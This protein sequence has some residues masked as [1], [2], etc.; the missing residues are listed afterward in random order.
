MNYTTW[1]RL[2]L[3]VLFIA[4]HGC[5]PAPESTTEAVPSPEAFLAEVNTQLEVLGKQGGAAGWVRSTYITED[6]G[7][8]AARASEDYLKFHSES[9]ARARVY[10]GQ[11]L[12]ARTR[13][14]LM[15]LKLGTSKPAPNDVTKRKQ[16]AEISVRMPG[17]YGAGKYC[18]DADEC[19]GLD[20]LEPIM[21]ASRDYDEL[22]EAWLGWR[23]ISPPMRDDYQQFVALAKEGARELG[24]SDLGEMW[25]SGYDMS[26]DEFRGEA[27]GLWEQVSPLYEELHCYVRDRLADTYGEDKVSRDGPIPAHLLGN[28]WAQ[29][30]GEIYDLV[31][32]YPGVADL[33]VDSALQE[34][35]YTAE[36]MTRNAESFFTSLGLPPLPDTFWER[37]MLLKPAD[38]EVICHASAWQVLGANDVRIKMCI[39]PIQ[40]H[41]TTIYHELGHIYY[42][43]A[44]HDK[45]ALHRSGAH[46]GFHEAIGDAITLSMTP[47]YL[48]SIGLVDSLEDSDKATI[49]TQMK[50]ALDKIAFLPF[51]KLI[52]EWR[53]DVFAGEIAPEHYNEGWWALR[54]E[55]Q[56][57]APPVAR[58]E[59]NFDPGAKY[60]IPGNTP[61]TRYFLSFIIQFQFQ[62]ALCDAAG[63]EG[64]LHECSVFGSK[65]AGA[66]FWAMLQAGSSEPWP[67]TLEKLTGTRNMDG[68][69]IIE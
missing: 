54:T 39:E 42:Y 3:A 45:P 19:A 53:W 33:D 34:Q 36:S 55:Y 67:D 11:Q 8:L 18:N 23:T 58:S 40:E 62:K 59:D 63:F 9:V 43:L 49:N 21:A 20:V 31:E 68:G 15:L 61:Y 12:D 27:K 65:Q 5:A 28:M 64:P 56:G 32:P 4:V 13:R 52:D 48:Q 25:R 41:L 10:D 57:I 50:M 14:D 38:R 7:V 22:L 44:Y 51:G 26:A 69:A 2:A 1:G 30:W 6:T 29:Q 66:P 16:L 47:A 35:N 37:S 24:F 17:V 46:D 60:H